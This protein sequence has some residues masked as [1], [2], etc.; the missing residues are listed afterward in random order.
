MDSV[1]TLVNI[2]GGEPSAAGADAPLRRREQ[3]NDRYRFST[4]LA[5]AIPPAIHALHR[6]FHLVED[7]AG[8]GPLSPELVLLNAD[9]D[10]SPSPGPMV[11]DGENFHLL[12][13]E[14]LQL[15]PQVQPLQR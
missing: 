12:S 14:I 8:G 1:R 6:C 5:E 11:N 3:V 2:R 10:R 9:P 4:L 7:G 15:L 13:P